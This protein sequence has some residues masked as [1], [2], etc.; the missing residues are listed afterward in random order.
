M[1]DHRVRSK[2]DSWGHSGAAVTR[3]L[4]YALQAGYLKAGPTASQRPIRSAWQAARLKA[5]STAISFCPSGRP[6]RG[7]M[8]PA[9]AP[10][11][12]GK[13]N[14]P[15]QAGT[16]VGSHFFTD[17]SR[18]APAQRSLVPPSMAGHPEMFTSSAVVMPPQRQHPGQNPKQ[19]QKQKQKQKNL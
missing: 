4:R 6:S 12:S 8:R 19:K 7:G 13:H 11:L 1:A 5:R 14:R 10:R 3:R 15:P 16:L 18:F 17:R 9:P 2:V